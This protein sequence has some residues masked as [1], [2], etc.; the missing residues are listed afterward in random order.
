MNKTF[1]TNFQIYLE[2]ALAVNKSLYE[3]NKIPFYIF[4]KAEDEI[5]KK[6]KSENT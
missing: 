4:K 6:I 2:L 1:N 5:L 3:E